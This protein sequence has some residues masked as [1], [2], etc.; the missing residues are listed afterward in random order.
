MSSPFFPGIPTD[1]QENMKGVINELVL[2]YFHQL[3]LAAGDVHHADDFVNDAA[4]IPQ[5]DGRDQFYARPTGGILSN[6]KPGFPS[7]SLREYI[8]WLMLDRVADDFV[9]VSNREQSRNQAAVLQVNDPGPSSA[10]RLEGI[11]FY[12]SIRM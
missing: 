2:Q 11:A 4:K 8:N 1:R 9:L 3:I 10:F 6:M 7:V 5:H 12:N